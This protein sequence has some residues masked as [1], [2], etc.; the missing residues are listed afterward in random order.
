[1]DY[2]IQT[3]TNNSY[4]ENNDIISSAY[5]DCSATPPMEPEV[6]DFLSQF[7]ASELGNAGSRT[8]EYGARAKSF[9][10][11]ARKNIANVVNAEAD[12]VIFTSGATESNNLAILGLAQYGIENNKKHIITTCIEHKAVLEPLD[13]LKTKGFDVTYIK[14]DKTGRV[15][16]EAVKA[17]LRKDTLLI[18]IMHVNN[19]TGIIQPIAEIC[20]I[21]KEHSAF[22]HVDAAQGF[23]KIFGSGIENQR[24]DLISV[25]SHK[26]YGPFG[27]G[28]LVCRRREFSLPPIK[29][30]IFGG[31]QERSLRP[32]TL[33]VPLI[34]GFGLASKLA[35]EKHAM[36]T[37]KNNQL[38]ALLVNELKVMGAIFNGDQEYAVPHTI[39]FSIPGIDSEAVM[40]ALKGIASISN[41]SACTSNNYQP[42][43]VLKGMGLADNI[44]DAALRV[45]WC[46]LNQKE[47]ILSL[48][49][50][51]KKLM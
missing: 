2:S 38:R 5:L 36:R 44:I 4:L 3:Q 24:V 47:D 13:F 31:G 39:N 35:S 20:E 9:V 41:G 48:T 15:D 6:A 51:L 32:G 30:L 29:P 50:G 7:Y 46:H 18:S 45:S 33:P 10:Q 49:N 37:K 19:E 11:S 27:V 40:V 28:A 14:I 42:S 25:S 8:H 21:L 1:M 22:F 43:H 23:G 26:M 34:A 16:P 12:E 17:A